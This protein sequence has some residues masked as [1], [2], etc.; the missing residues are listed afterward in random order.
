MYVPREP[1]TLSESF[2]NGFRG[3]QPAWGPLGY[4][5]YVRTY[6]AEKQ[7]GTR[8]EFWETCRRVIEGMYQIQKGHCRQLGLPWSDKKAQASAQEAYSRMFAFKWL[9]AGRGLAKMG[10]ENMFK[11][12]GA[13]L[14]SCGFTTTANTANKNIPY[15]FA[16][17]FVWLMDMSMLGVGVGLDIQGTGLLDII[18]PTMNPEPYVIEDSRE[19]WVAYTRELLQSY[20]DPKVL[21]PVNPDYSKIRP[22]GA[23]LN[24]FGG[25]ASGYEALA[26]M[27]NRIHQLLYSNI[28]NPV[29]SRIIVDIA[30]SIGECVVAGGV[31]RS[32]EILLGTPDDPDFLYLKDPS[33]P[34]LITWPRW[35]SNNSLIVDSYTDFG[36]LADMTVKN[37]EPGYLFLENARAYSRMREDE[38][39]HAD[40]NA[41]GTNP[42]NEQTLHD[43]ELCVLTESFPSKCD[44]YKDFERSIKFAYLYA[45]T[46][47]LV[48][49]HDP[50]TNAVML[51]NRRIGCSQTGIQD[52]IVRRGLR[53]HL[54]WCDRGFKYIKELDKLYSDWL[55]IP[56]SIKHTSVKPSG[57]I[58]KLVG[59]REGIHHA[60]GEYELQAIR[61]NDDSPIIPVLRDAGYRIETAVNEANTVVV[62]F[63][64]HYPGHPK[65]QPTMWDQLEMA[66]H[67]QREWA[68]NQVS[69][70]VDFDPETEGPLIAKALKTYSKHLKGV[71]F[72]PR[73]S[74]MYVQAPKTVITKEEYETYLS[75]LKPYTLSQT[76]AHEVDDKFC[77]SGV[78]LI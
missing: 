43:R 55:C 41:I 27:S 49:T 71:S 52:N 34:D 26:K 78:C 47:T 70:T 20:V 45:K 12:G 51:K 76:A 48:P 61:I 7:D 59:V 75:Q 4:V 2:I 60:K 17:P 9:P 68:D 46:V 77:D 6:A 5:V 8:E 23:K 14:C 22:K 11:I 32:S 72:L 42:C 56:R 73:D 67:M 1:F 21:C 24:G 36:P 33:N 66:V 16:S 10:T 39:D 19:G 30:N 18:P 65:I 58:S 63:P 74:K 15:A 54:N 37:G 3:L 50:N 25:T 62:Y 69:V 64:M 28:R 53:E 38:L 29:T 44:N 31:R 35:A 13:C 40:D 57:S